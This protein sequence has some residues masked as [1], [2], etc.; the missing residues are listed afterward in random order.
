MSLSRHRKIIFALLLISLSGI[1][2]IVSTVGSVS[3]PVSDVFKVL[4]SPIIPSQGESLKNSFKIIILLVRLPRIILSVITGMGLAVSGAVFQ[5]IFRNPMANPYILGVSSGAAFGVALGMTLQLQI[6]F[7]GLGAVPLSAFFGGM[8]T[9][10]VVYFISGNGRSI[11]SLLLSGIAMGF[12]LSALMSLIMYLN[13]DQLENIVYW[14]MGSFNA[15]SWIKILISGPV[16][17]LGSAV[18]MI[19]SKDLN[20]LILGDDTAMSLGVAVR[21]KRLFFLIISTI[22]TASAV[23]ASGVIGFVGLIIPHTLRILTGPDHRTLLPLSMISGGI[24]L[25]LSDTI[26]RTLLSPTEVP[27]G[28]IT[29]LFGAPFFIY[30]LHKRRKALV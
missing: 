12:F 26:A 15:A 25:L 27:V 22:I 23:S 3:I 5:G 8:L 28:I 10:L 7:L 13:R 9:A 29:S 21:A 1:M 6:S 14:S 2:L 20:I 18:I 16:I 24:F 4:I 17:L 11:F 19:F 30:L